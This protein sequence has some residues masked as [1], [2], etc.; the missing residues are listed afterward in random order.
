M[1]PFPC[2]PCCVDDVAISMCTMQ[3]PF[4]ATPKACSVRLSSVTT[5]MC[6]GLSVH[7]TLSS[8]SEAST[9]QP[10]TVPASVSVASKLDD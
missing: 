9:Y 4:T 3:E 2:A 10:G 7:P 6:P 5:I 8:F 1:W